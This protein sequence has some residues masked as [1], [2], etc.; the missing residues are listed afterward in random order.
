RN[1][2]VIPVIPLKNTIKIVGEDGIIR[3]TPDRS[4][5]RLAQT[6]QAFRREIILEAYRSAYREGFYGTDDASL[7]E[8]MGVP[9]QTIPGLYDNIKI[10]TPGDLDLGEL[11]LKKIGAGI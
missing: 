10:T 8:R 4:D 9:V 11:L 5:L 2:A 6:P 7:V 3:D 1:G